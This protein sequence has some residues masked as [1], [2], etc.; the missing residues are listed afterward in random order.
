MT[1]GESKWKIVIEW[2]SK[3][4]R[5]PIHASAFVCMN[6][7]Y[8]LVCICDTVGTWS[9]C[10]AISLSSSERGS[11]FGQSVSLS[12]QGSAST[13]HTYPGKAP[14]PSFLALF[15]TGL[16]LTLM[17]PYK[18]QYKVHNQHSIFVCCSYFSTEKNPSGLKYRHS[19]A[20]IQ[21]NVWWP[22]KWYPVNKSNH[23]MFT[24]LILYSCLDV[25]PM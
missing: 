17:Q 14:R 25:Y 10:N 8:T 7:V 9:R 11:V 18:I 13:Q 2:G 6:S 19:F 23:S 22:I 24:N 21:L 20:H 15:R 4:M 3:W 1:R 12:H 5:L 16:Y